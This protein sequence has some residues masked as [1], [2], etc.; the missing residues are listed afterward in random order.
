MWHFKPVVS[1]RL[2]T[3]AATRTNC[4][5]HMDRQKDW[6]I[7]GIWYRYIHTYIHTYI[8]SEH[9][10]MDCLK[11]CRQ[12]CVVQKRKK[13]HSTHHFVLLQPSQPSMYNEKKDRENLSKDDIWK[14]G[15]DP[16]ALPATNTEIHI[17]VHMYIQSNNITVTEQKRI[18]CH[19]SDVRFNLKCSNKSIYLRNK[20]EYLSVYD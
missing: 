20:I 2:L 12:N 10:K 8:L 14:R 18:R 17:Y 3:T 13:K 7:H 5:R 15:N 16:T 19:S 11:G 4:N 1:L 6:Y 9:I